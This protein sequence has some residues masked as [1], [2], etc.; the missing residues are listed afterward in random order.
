MCKKKSNLSKTN[1]SSKA[2]EGIDTDSRIRF[3]KEML[4]KHSSVGDFKGAIAV[5]EECLAFVSQLQGPGAL[6]ELG[7]IHYNLS[8]LQ[9]SSG[10]IA[11]AEKQGKLAL[12]YSTLDNEQNPDSP[13]ALEL[14]SVVLLGESY[15]NIEMGKIEAAETESLQA[16]KII[17][18]IHKTDDPQMVKALRG[19][20][21]VR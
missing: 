8:H 21:I 14:L 1:S 2:P 9:L 18:R 20:A 7:Q 19:V 16:L 17:E 5:G 4:Q 15:R 11:E 12:K 6:N 3:Y 13:H 10:N